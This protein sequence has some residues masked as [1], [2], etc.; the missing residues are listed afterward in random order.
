[1]EQNKDMI[2][3]L[4][5]VSDESGGVGSELRSEVGCFDNLFSEDFVTFTVED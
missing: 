3:Y 2:F 1:M 5:R 4:V